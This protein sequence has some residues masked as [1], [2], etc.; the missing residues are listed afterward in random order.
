MFNMAYDFASLDNSINMTADLAIQ[1]I[2]IN[3]SNN[4]MLYWNY[5]PQ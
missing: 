4:V 3:S 1:V 2:L 5:W